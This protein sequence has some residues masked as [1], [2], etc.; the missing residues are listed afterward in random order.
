MPSWT[1]AA[2]VATAAISHEPSEDRSPA[3]D[4]RD[5]A[6]FGQP[7]VS[8][9]YRPAAVGAQRLPLCTVLAVAHLCR[10]GCRGPAPTA[11]TPSCCLVVRLQPGASRRPRARTGST[12][13]N[14]CARSCGQPPAWRIKCHPVCSCCRSFLSWRRR[15]RCSMSSI[16]AAIKVRPYHG[17]SLAWSLCSNCAGF[18]CGPGR[19]AGGGAGDCHPLLRL[20]PPARRGRC[21]TAVAGAA[22]ARRGTAAL[23]AVRLL[24]ER[25]TSPAS[26]WY[27]RRSRADQLKRASRSA[28]SSACRRGVAFAACRRSRCCFG[29]AGAVAVA[30]A[31][32]P[33]L[34]WRRWFAGAAQRRLGMV[35]V[36]RL[37][38]ESARGAGRER[39]SEAR[40]VSS[41]RAELE[42]WPDDDHATLWFAG[43]ASGE[44][45][46]R[47]TARSAVAGQGRAL[48]ALVITWPSAADGEPDDDAAVERVNHGSA[49]RS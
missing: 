40:A 27:V 22:A 42:G 9:R 36:E 29:L 3:P 8:N 43:T 15:E 7:P 4:R 20:R 47:C 5:V 2:S 44:R 21:L 10:R 41:L 19:G 48:M 31:Q 12:A 1:L 34:V 16:K 49:R 33:G 13:S 6:R 14:C 39:R 11:P 28:G 23:G 46:R 35:E 18:C 17:S 45:R 37:G 30:G 24:S 32:A 26:T 25:K 38:S